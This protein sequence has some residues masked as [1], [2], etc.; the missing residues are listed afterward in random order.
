MRV[1]ICICT[2]NRP[3]MLERLLDALRHVDLGDLELEGVDI[4]VV[5]N[6]PSGAARGVCA[7]ASRS[8]PFPIHLAEETRRGIAFARNRAV[9]EALARRA[10]FIAFL[11]D[12]DIPQRDWLLE[13]LSRQRETGADLVGGTWRWQIEPQASVWARLAPMFK[14]RD[15]SKRKRGIP[16]WMA[17][18]NVL[19][20]RRAV[21]CLGP[22][23]TV[24]SHDFGDLGSEDTDF[25]IRARNG[26]ATIEVAEKSVVNRY[27]EDHRLTVRGMLR[28]AFRRG[29]AEVHLTRKHE[30]PAGLRRAKA[31]AIR[32]LG[33][34]L[35]V[36]PAAIFSKRLL[37]RRIYATSY[38]LGM[39]YG[40]FGGQ[41]E[42]YR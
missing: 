38:G 28:Y 13:L 25:F 39:L 17:T 37:A 40:F 35:V 24:F 19:I 15:V 29:N 34:S 42:Y 2:C 27:Y 5:D 8:H 10:D 20:G 23:P 33:L 18:C 7:Q 30:P 21:E 12:D 3:R 26:G 6:D 4:V 16:S 9:A 31:K 11:D 32:K 41:F 22:E 1:S 14:T 36:L